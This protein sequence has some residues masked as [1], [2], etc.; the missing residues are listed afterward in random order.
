M[1]TPF[2]PLTF[3]TGT[4]VRIM[5][6]YAAYGV[7]TQKIGGEKRVVVNG[8]RDFGYHPYAEFETMYSERLQNLLPLLR[9]YRALS[10]PLPDNSIPALTVARI[11]CDDRDDDFQYELVGGDDVP[12]VVN[13]YQMG[14]G[15][16]LRNTLKIL[17]NWNFAWFNSKGNE[18]RMRCVLE[19]YDYLRSQ[20]FAL[21]V[22]GKKLVAGVDFLV[23]EPSTP[24][25][26][27]VA[28]DA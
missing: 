1:S 2:Q 10:L 27:K 19:A 4:T 11:L 13:V 6:Q 20:L 24:V 16:E 12:P 15:K 9:D 26:N 3:T 21:P 5:A 17:P 18:D 25:E 7:Q 8:L 28:A 22:C 23:L 14:G